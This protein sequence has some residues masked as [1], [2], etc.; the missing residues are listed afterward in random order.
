MK[1]FIALNKP[2]EATRVFLAFNDATD[3][4]AGAQKIPR[5]VSAFMKYAKDNKDIEKNDLFD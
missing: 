3:S 5:A 4:T 1:L 2:K